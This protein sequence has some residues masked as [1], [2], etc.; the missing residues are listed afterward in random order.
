MAYSNEKMIRSGIHWQDLGADLY[1]V[2]IYTMITIA[3]L[4]LP[5]LSETIIRSALGLGMVLFIPGYV[6]V[7]VLFPDNRG[8][9]RYERLALSLG[10]S[11]AVA[12]LTGLALS[13]VPGGL[14]LG[15]IVFCLSAFSIVGMAVAIIRR[16]RV[17]PESRFHIDAATVYKKLKAVALTPGTGRLDRLLT[18][19][20]ILAIIGSIAMMAALITMPRQG[21]AFTEFY[22]LGPG[23]KAENYP[24]ELTVGETGTVNVVVANHEY[25]EVPYDLVIRLNDSGNISGVL[26]E[27]LVLQDNQT[28]KRKVSIMPDHPGNSTQVEFLLYADGNLTAPYRDLRLWIDV[29]PPLA[30]PSPANDTVLESS[31]GNTEG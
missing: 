24:T 3:A 21:E 10:M 1:F 11:I 22:I 28:W 14:R 19:I 26:S 13:L 17:K 18:F 27:K 4:Y 9:D 8:I 31:S 30:T 12:I 25:R 16:N 2:V 6:L 5:V 20:L 23:D 15:P 7:S 29:A